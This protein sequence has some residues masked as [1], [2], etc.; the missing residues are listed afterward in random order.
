MYARLA[1]FSGVD[2]STS[3]ERAERLRA[4]I[5][6]VRSGDLP[7]EMPEQAAE[8]LRENVVRVLALAGS[9]DEELSLVFTE[10]EDGMRAVDRV[11]DGMTP[12]GGDG[13]RS[14]VETFE[15]LVDAA[16]R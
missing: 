1:R 7:D 15:V 2:P 13:H 9:G 4:S 11:L 6:A 10:T 3:R 16:P 8:V 5:E 14:D 12:P